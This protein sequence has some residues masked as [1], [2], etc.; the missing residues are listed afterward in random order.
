MGPKHFLIPSGE[1]TLRN[2]IKP[3]HLLLL[4]PSKHVRAGRFS[5]DKHQRLLY[6]SRQVLDSNN[7]HVLIRWKNTPATTY[8][9][10]SLDRAT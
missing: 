10:M 9:S 1:F 2:L 7:A 4:P 5:L 6:S 3:L 8:I